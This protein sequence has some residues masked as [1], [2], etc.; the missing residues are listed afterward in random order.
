MNCELYTFDKENEQH[1]G[2][3]FK[4]FY[5][6]YMALGNTEQ[7]GNGNDSGCDN[8]LKDIFFVG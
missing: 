3:P 1:Y 5:Y 4:H 2:I 7:S 6:P 8:D